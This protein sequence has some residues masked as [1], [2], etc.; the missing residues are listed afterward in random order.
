MCISSDLNLKLLASSES[1]SSTIFTTSFSKARGIVT[2]KKEVPSSTVCNKP[3]EECE[4]TF[5]YYFK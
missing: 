4:A 2:D 1:L 3:E 5:Y